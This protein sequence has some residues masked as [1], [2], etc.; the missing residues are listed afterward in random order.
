MDSSSDVNE[1]HHGSRQKRQ[2]NQFADN[3]SDNRD[4]TPESVLDSLGTLPSLLNNG[5]PDLGLFIPDANFLS[6]IQVNNY[7]MIVLISYT[8]LE[9]IQS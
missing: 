8:F 7:F 1:P 6:S 4:E 5:D 2:F 9:S 3:P